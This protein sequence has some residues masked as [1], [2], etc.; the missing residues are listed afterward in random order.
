MQETVKIAY[1]FCYVL[2]NRKYIQLS[3]DLYDNIGFISC[4]VFLC[5]VLFF[6]VLQVVSIM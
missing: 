6:T 1:A 3:I 5:F 2:F 4:L